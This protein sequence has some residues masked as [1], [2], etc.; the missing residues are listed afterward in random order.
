MAQFSF[1]S[2]YLPRVYPM[3]L[4]GTGGSF[5]TNMGGR[6]IGTMGAFLNTE[7]LSTQFSGTSAEQIASAAAVI[8]GGVFF[9]AFLATFLLP[10]PHA[11][12]EKQEVVFGKGEALAEPKSETVD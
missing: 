9:I 7:L 10:H 11:E 6:M 1:L 4:R 8:G 2:E 5:A 3:H 12:V